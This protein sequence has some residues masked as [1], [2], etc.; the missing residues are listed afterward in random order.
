M[1]NKKNIISFLLKISLKKTKIFIIIKN[2]SIQPIS[3]LIIYNID[4]MKNNLFKIHYKKLYAVCLVD[5][6]MILN[7]KLYNSKYFNIDS[8]SLEIV[9]YEKN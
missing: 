8:F 6:Y 2:R 1:Y 9:I 7:F 4:M 3:K 5:A